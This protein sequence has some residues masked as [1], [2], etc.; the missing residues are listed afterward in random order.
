MTGRKR[1]LSA[2]CGRVAVCH[3]RWGS[4]TGRAGGWEGQRS[5]SGCVVTWVPS[6]LL[7]FFSIK[8]VFVIAL[9]CLTHVC[10][11]HIHHECVHATGHVESEDN[12]QEL[13][14]SLLWFL[15][16]HSHGQACVVSP[17]KPSGKPPPWVLRQSFSLETELA[18]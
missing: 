9:M 2:N 3:T 11:Y 15:G 6:A 7:F 1:K 10:A 13:V 5:A 14:L 12:V 16:I 17:T 4:V 18:G 8:F